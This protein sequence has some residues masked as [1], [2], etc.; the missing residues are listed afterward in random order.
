MTSAADVLKMI[1]DKEVKFVDLRFTDTRGKEQHVSVPAKAFGQD[2]FDAGHA[3]DGSSIAGWKGIQASDMLLMPDPGTAVL[4]PFMDETTLLITCDVIEPSDG[5]GYERD[6]RSLAKRA[7]VY[8]Q[9]HRTRRHGVLRTGARVLHLRRGRVVRR[10]VG[11]YCKIFSS[12]AAW[13]SAE[14]FEGGNMGHRPTVKGGYFPVP[15]VDSLQDIRSAMCLAHGADGR[16]GRGASPRGRQ[17]RPVRDRHQVRAAGQARR[18]AADPQVLR[19]QHRRGVRQD[20]DVHAEAHRRRQRLGMHCHQSVWKEGKNL[21]DGGGYAGL[22]DFALY[23]IGGII[24]HAKALNAFT[25]PGT[26]SYKRLVPASRR[27]STSRT[28]RATA[29][30]PCAC[31]T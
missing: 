21:F 13:S 10:H 25:N 6:P 17:R 2:K 3:F 28:P 8:P 23:Y 29:R 22:S 1:K 16:R 20:R 26:N 5:K 18:L 12:E 4:D 9:V 30:L 24:K 31:R 15:P 11:S 7:E 27:R 19:A 14:K